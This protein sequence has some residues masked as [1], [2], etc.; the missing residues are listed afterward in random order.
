MYNEI[1]EIK[2]QQ[3]NNQLNKLNITNNDQVSRVGLLSK[4]QKQQIL[5]YNQQQITQ[6]LLSPVNSEKIQ[7]IFS[8]TNNQSLNNNDKNQ[9]TATSLSCQELKFISPRATQIQKDSLKDLKFATNL[10]NKSPK[11]NLKSDNNL[12]VKGNQFDIQ[13]QNQN[14]IC[15]LAPRGFKNTDYAKQ[16]TKFQHK[17]DYQSTSTPF[18]YNY[19]IIQKEDKITKKQKVQ[20]IQYDIASINSKDSSSASAKRQL[21]QIMADKSLLQ[22][23][24]YGVVLSFSNMFRSFGFNGN[25]TGNSS[26]NSNS[27]AEYYMISNEYQG[28][29]AL[30]DSQNQMVTQQQNEKQG[31]LDQLTVLMILIIT[32]N[33]ICVS[34]IL[35][36]YYYIQ[37]ERDIQ[38]SYCNQ[39]QQSIHSNKNSTLM[40]QTIASLQS[41]SKEKDARKQN[42]SSITQLPR[43]DPKIAIIVFFNYLLIMCYPIIIKIVTQD[44]LAKTTL[45]LHTIKKVYRLR[46]YLLENI[47]INFNVI[48]MKI[49]PSLKPMPP[50]IYNDYLNNLNQ[51]YNQNLNDSFFFSAFKNNLCDVFNQY[52]Q[53]NTNSTKLNTTICNSTNQGFLQQGF[54]VAFK[55]TLYLIPELYRMYTIPDNKTSVAKISQFLTRFNIID[56]ILYTEFLDECIKFYIEEIYRL[57]HACNMIVSDVD[58]NYE[59]KTVDYLAR[60]FSYTQFSF[61]II[62][63]LFFF[64]GIIFS[65][66]G[67]SAILA[68]Y[69]VSSGFI[70]FFYSQYYNKI[71]QYLNVFMHISLFC[72]SVI[73]QAGISLKFPQNLISLMFIVFLPL[74]FKITQF[75]VQKFHQ[76]IQ[77][78][79]QILG[80]QKY[81]EA[82]QLDKIV[83]LNLF[84][85]VSDSRQSEKEEIKLMNLVSNSHSSQL[86]PLFKFLERYNLNL[87]SIQKTQDFQHESNKFKKQEQQMV[88][89]QI[90]QIIAEQ[91]K[92]SFK[93]KNRK[94]E[95]IFQQQLNYFVF[96]IEITQSHRIYWIQFLQLSMAKKLSIKQIQLFN[97]VHSIFLKQRAINRKLMG[98]ANPFDCSYLEVIVFEKRL[99]YSY[100]IFDQ[101]IKVKLELLNIMKYKE[102]EVTMLVKKIELFQELKARLKINLNTLSLMNDES[103][104]LLNIQALFLENLAFSEK[105]INLMQINKYRRKHQAKLNQKYINY[106][107]D[108]VSS[109]INN[110][111]FDEKTCI[112]FANYKDKTSIMINEVSSNFQDIFQYTTNNDIKGH[113]IGSIIPHIFQSLHNKYIENYLEE[114]I[115]NCIDD[116]NA[117]EINQNNQNQQNENEEVENLEAQNKNKNNQFQ[118]LDKQFLSKNNVNIQTRGC[119]MNNQ[120]IFAQ[121]NQIFILPVRIDIRINQIY[122]TRVFGLTAKIK[123]INNEFDYILFDEKNLNTIGLTEKIHYTLFPYQESLQRINI[124]KVFP[125]LIGTQEATENSQNK[126]TKSNQII[127]EFQQ[128]EKH[129]PNLAQGGEELL[130][131]SSSKVIKKKQKINF[132]VIQPTDMMRG[133]TTVI[134]STLSLKKPQAKIKPLKQMKTTQA[135]FKD[136]NSYNFYFV[137]LTLHKVKYTGVENVSYIEIQKMRQLNFNEQAS[138]ILQQIKHPKKQIFYLQLFFQYELDR[139]IQELEQKALIQNIQVNHSQLSSSL[140]AT[141]ALN[142][143]NHQISSINQISTAGSPFN[144]IPNQQQSNHLATRHKQQSLTIEDNSN[145]ENLKQ[146]SSNLAI[147]QP[148]IKEQEE[149]KYSL[150]HSEIQQNQIDIRKYIEYDQMQ[151][152]L[153]IQ[154]KL[155]AVNNNLNYQHDQSLKTQDQ[156]Q[157]LYQFQDESAYMSQIQNNQYQ[158]NQLNFFQIFDNNQNYSNLIEKSVNNEISYMN[159]NQFTNQNIINQNLNDESKMNISQNKTNIQN[160]ISAADASKLEFLQKN[161]NQQYQYIQKQQEM[162]IS[163]S[164]QAIFS[165]TATEKII[166]FPINSPLK[167]QQN[168]MS[169]YNVN[170]NKQTAAG[171]TPQNFIIISPHNS[172][173][174]SQQLVLDSNAMKSNNFIQKQLQFRSDNFL[175]P[176]LPEE[177]ENQIIKSGIYKKFQPDSKQVVQKNIH[178]SKIANDH[179]QQQFNEIYMNL[180][181][182]RQTDLKEKYNNIYNAQITKKGDNLSLRSPSGENHYKYVKK[183]DKMTKKQKVQDIQYDI[184]ST[185]SKESSSASAKRQLQQIMADKSILQVIKGMN[186]IGILCFATMISITWVQYTQMYQNLSS[187]NQDY[188]VFDFPTKYSSSLS[189]ILKYQNT[190]Y[191]LKYS[192]QLQ[193]DTPAIKQAFKSTTSLNMRGTFNGMNQMLTEMQSTNVERKVFVLMRQTYFL[194]SIG[195]YYNTSQLTGTSSIPSQLVAIN[196]NSSLS[197]GLIMAYQHVFRYTNNLGNGRPEYYLIDNQ[198]KEIE[199]LKSVQNEMLSQQ[200]NKQKQIQDQLTILMVVIIVINAGCLGIIIPLYY[201]IQKERDTILLLFTTFS[202]QKIDFLIKK[203]QKQYFSFKTQSLNSIKNSQSLKQTVMQFQAMNNEKD[204]RK[205]N[206]STITK[207]PRFNLKINISTLVIFVI[208]ICYPIVNKIVSQDYLDKSILDLST[209][210]KVYLLRS[211]LLENISMDFN[212]LVMKINPTLKP[213]SPTIYYDYLNQLIQQQ[214]SVNDEI[215]WIVSSQFQEKRYNQELYDNFFFTAFKTNLCELFDKYPQF[216]T[217]STKINTKICQSTH[218]GFLMQGLQVAY[219]HS[220]QLFPQLYNMFNLTDKKQ[221]LNQVQSFLSTFNIQDYTIF[222]EFLDETIISL[223]QFIITQGNNFYD[224]IILFQTIL[225]SIQ[226]VIMVLVFLLGWLS[227]SRHLNDSLHQTKNYLQILDINTLIENTYILTY[228][229]KNTI[230]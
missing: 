79:I 149:D 10:L 167:T 31:I 137:E 208:I 217:N 32:I 177:T 209:I 94:K 189:E 53:Y 135:S 25:G 161:N 81:N 204:L 218:Q 47:A 119:K 152:S 210:M 3:S 178:D 205:Q 120:I 220:L 165:P 102:I 60:P 49:N 121:L 184:A 51:Q 71:S 35:P 62:P 115:S 58:Y 159:V 186:Y 200:Q 203:I 181:A 57:S 59:I 187:S 90:L 88:K 219:K 15:Q 213:M 8:P 6:N 77:D 153:M 112:I 72:L 104:D 16:N 12:E 183:E 151:P 95:S 150:I 84:N 26:A 198:L 69:Y 19:P 98:R 229:K 193:F 126:Q 105:D 101:A 85:E 143:L 146:K 43:F 176:K 99:E 182:H 214:Q 207:L 131:Q 202:T 211:Y 54:E 65:P 127:E 124:K 33:G 76:I 41:I 45:D 163:P 130:K 24:K 155:A 56:Y 170:S 4:P 48:V 40:K 194:F 92:K 37:K 157:D 180:N 29:Q 156:M 96:L 230:I 110:D 11:N 38:R 1:D 22:I 103:L 42:I 7:V 80:S 145:L 68:C 109:T 136:L 125:F 64:L 73:I 221:S 67:Q 106:E 89:K 216:N 192:T 107:E 158:Q 44:Y 201:H 27:R 222:T 50:T 86:N 61:N 83:R 169:N 87:K 138:F 111:R 171:Q 132:V 223:K 39:K 75:T 129:H 128:K 134:S 113:N 185:N 215:Q 168:F 17:E 226:M 197:Y 144:T 14:Y 140:Q 82:I 212:V 228:I 93:E 166:S 36:L 133:T 191:L 195:Q 123:H 116:D 52:P 18:R 224:Q 34:I 142:P 2:I 188:Q 141:S 227:F 20:E 173:Q 172:Q 148:I 28:L 74:C 23:I 160:N 66:K 225:I 154:Q 206:I 70:S 100:N 122:E 147:E 175:S 199:K 46:S 139:I 162:L 13:I 91:F 63:E 118:K 97:S 5:Q 117:Q 55:Q 9:Q 179:S 30:K 190:I 196:Y 21:L 164:T 108:L 78:S 114:E 174:S